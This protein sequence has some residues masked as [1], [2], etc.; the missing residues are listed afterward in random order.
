MTK[1]TY[2]ILVLVSVVACLAILTLSATLSGYSIGGQIPYVEKITGDITDKDGKFLCR[3]SIALVNLATKRP[4]AWGDYLGGT[5]FTM[6]FPPK[7][8]EYAPELGVYV[9]D[10]NNEWVPCMRI[11]TSVLVEKA[12]HSNSLGHNV[13]CYFKNVDCSYILNT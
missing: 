6:R 13:K 1:I 9:T 11:N 4:V 12:R 10:S 7:D 5:G 2:L 3:G 8:W